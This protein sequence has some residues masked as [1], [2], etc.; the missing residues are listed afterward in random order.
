MKLW[1]LPGLGLLASLALTSSLYAQVPGIPAAPAV[2]A[3]PG[4]IP[5]GV[6]GAAAPKNLWSFFCLTPDQAAACKAKICNSPLGAML[7]SAAGPLSAASGGMIGANCGTP[8]AADLA[9]MAAEGTLDSA[10]G[11]AAKIK[12]EEA[13]AKARR[14]AVRYLGTVDCTYF[15]AARDVLIKS[16]REDTN[17][18][19]RY[20]AALALGRGC[21][22]N[23]KTIEALKDCVNGGKKLG[24]REPSSRV[25]DAAD[26]ALAHCAAIFQDVRE[27]PKTEERKEKGREGKEEI[28]VSTPRTVKRGTGLFGIIASASV[29]PKTIDPAAFVPPPTKEPSIRQTSPNVMPATYKPVPPVTNSTNENV[30]YP[31]TPVAVPA[32]EQTKA[33]AVTKPVDI[34]DEASLPFVPDM[35]PS[36]FQSGA[37]ATEATKLPVV[38]TI[39]PKV[40]PVNKQAVPMP[41]ELLKEP[42]FESLAPKVIPARNQP[43]LPPAEKTSDNSNNSSSRNKITIIPMKESAT[44]PK[45]TMPVNAAFPVSTPVPTRPATFNTATERDSNPPFATSDAVRPVPAAPAPTRGYVT[46]DAPGGR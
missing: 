27:A 14:D 36:T 45:S 7:K 8:T 33:P 17:E 9:K 10:G 18:C 6:P 46:F 19:V 43:S 24:P 2:P 34:I 1:K 25:R 22:C 11:T 28:K 26:D 40:A 32:K 15:P 12:K 37:K 30:I 21:C 44:A 23:E 3:A 16:L 20:E 29:P 42:V 41:P 31:V 39:A 38:S 35:V 5:G 4:A 13:E